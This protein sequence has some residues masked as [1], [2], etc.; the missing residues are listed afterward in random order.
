MCIVCYSPDTESELVP[1]CVE[2]EKSEPIWTDI[3]AASVLDLDIDLST[4]GENSQSSPSTEFEA[5]FICQRLETQDI[6]L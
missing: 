6:L 5:V 4:H 1:I 3:K 2:N